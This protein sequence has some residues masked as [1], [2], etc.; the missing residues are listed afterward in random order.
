MPFWK[1]AFT[2]QK[3]TAVAPPDMPV[4]RHSHGIAVVAVVVE[5]FHSMFDCVLLKGK[6]GGKCL[7]QQIIKL[8]V[9]KVKTAEMVD[10]HSDALVA[11]LGELPFQLHV[12]PYFGGRHLVNRDALSWLGDNEYF[13]IRLGFLASPEKL[14]H[15]P[16]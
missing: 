10:K 16:R 9:N 15:G 13:I 6:L 1:C 7:C 11:L 4:G 12:K 2:P 5:D 3:V 8:K 14:G